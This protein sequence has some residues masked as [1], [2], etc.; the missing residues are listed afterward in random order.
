MLSSFA[1]A[2]EDVV[3]VRRGAD[4]PAFVGQ[5]NPRAF[6]GPIDRSAQYGEFGCGGRGALREERGERGE[7][8]RS[9][10][11]RRAPLRAVQLWRPPVVGSAPGRG[12]ILER[13]SI[14]V[15]RTSSPGRLSAPC[16]IMRDN[17]PLATKNGGPRRQHELEANQLASGAGRRVREHDGRPSEPSEIPLDELVFRAVGATDAQSDR[18]TRLFGHESLRDSSRQTRCSQ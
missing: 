4:A 6:A 13:A 14:R 17:V 15:K 11:V 10:W 2:R 5:A 12:I 16:D 7:P 1:Q 3:A 18:R 8:R 9:S